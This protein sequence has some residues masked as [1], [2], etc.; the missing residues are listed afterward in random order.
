ML[1]FFETGA[2][3]RNP[4]GQVTGEG[5]VSASMWSEAL[6]SLGYFATKVCVRANSVRVAET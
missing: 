6:S 2:S 3:K 1:S 4:V 5:W